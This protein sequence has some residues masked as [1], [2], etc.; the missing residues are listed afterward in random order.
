M[1]ASIATYFS[2]WS[3]EIHSPGAI[4]YGRI[5]SVWARSRSSSSNLRVTLLFELDFH[6]ER[7]GKVA[8]RE[9]EKNVTREYRSF[10][11][12]VLVR[13]HYRECSVTAVRVNID[14][15]TLLENSRCLSNYL[16][17]TIYSH[18]HLSLFL[19]IFALHFLT[20]CRKQTKF[21]RFFFEV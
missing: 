6:S 5:H 11:L 4:R 19:S 17:L 2:I 7:I 1:S 16:K 12:C 9:Q 10:E 15:H 13:V 8:L 3:K 14:S 20:S 21:S 18:I